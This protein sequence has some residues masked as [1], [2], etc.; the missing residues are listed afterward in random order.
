M[1]EAE[2][3]GAFLL[4]DGI[5]NPLGYRRL[6]NLSVVGATA[7]ERGEVFLLERAWSLIG[8]LEL[9]IVRLD[10]AGIRPG[11]VLEPEELA[12][13]KPPLLVDNF[14]GIAA[15][16]TPEGRTLLY[17]LSDDNFN[18]VQRTLLTVFV[19]D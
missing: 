7:T 6:R 15:R 19:V 12:T 1:I 14:E 4:Q 5:W 10:A 13:L 16:V 2:G 17:L 18:A 11:A 8:G 9:R 3:G